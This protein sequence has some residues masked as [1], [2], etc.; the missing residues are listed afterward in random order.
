M[1]LFKKLFS[2]MKN[3]DSEMDFAASELK[4]EKESEFQRDDTNSREFFSREDSTKDNSNNINSEEINELLGPVME[5]LSD[6]NI[7][8]VKLT[9]DN[10]KNIQTKYTKTVI[11]KDGK[12]IYE[13]S[14]GN[15][16]EL[17]EIVNEL[18]D[19]IFNKK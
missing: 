4:K 15:N 18:F 6:L 1:S 16:G 10:I 2:K 17:P 7:D 8:N 3:S 5:I 12:Q 19:N 9:E 14:S 13:S 11:T